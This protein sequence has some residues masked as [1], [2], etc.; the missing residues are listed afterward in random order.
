MEIDKLK[1]LSGEPIEVCEGVT[2]YQPTLR[3]IKNFGEQAFFST[4]WQFCS[5][6]WDMPAFFD[7]LGIDFMKVS[8]WEFFRSI[9]M[10]CTPEQTSLIFGDLDFSSFEQYVMKSPESDDEQ[11]VL[12]RN[13][14]M[15]I[16]EEMY[17]TFIPYVQEMI[18][19]SHKGRKA[20][21]KATAKILIMDDR[22]SRERDKDK[23]YESM[24]FDTIISLV[25]TEEF[26]YTYESV[27]DI[28]VYQLIKSLTQIQGKKSAC[29]LYQGS[30][31]GMMDT[32]GIPAIDFSW[33]YSEEKYKPRGKKLINTKV[34]N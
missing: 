6:A 11:I 32:S 9:A 3:E 18:G 5:A 2:I 24:L 14:G 7:D 31:S 27:F 4:F 26:K 34:K 23:P 21:N 8:D 33:M 17:K 25:N 22:R 29:A 28:T 10:S 30:M 12:A 15:I 19:F 16:T 1:I 20:A 13:D